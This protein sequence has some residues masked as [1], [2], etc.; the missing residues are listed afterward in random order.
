MDWL[1]RKRSVESF[2]SGLQTLPRR[3]QHAIAIPTPF[4]LLRPPCDFLCETSVVLRDPCCS[5]FRPPSWM[6]TYILRLGSAA[7]KIRL[8]RGLVGSERIGGCDTDRLGTGG[9]CAGEYLHLDI[10]LDLLPP[11]LSIP[12]PQTP[13]DF[14]FL[15]IPCCWLTIYHLSGTACDIWKRWIG[16]PMFERTQSRY[17]G[18]RDVEVVA[19]ERFW[20][21]GL[22]QRAIV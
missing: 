22:G 18:F 21:R 19:A 20:R 3:S 2:S 4:A 15:R 11:L 17:A 9:I 1:R 13:Y 10:S 7:H 16:R 12:T 14:A 8:G 6:I 5:I